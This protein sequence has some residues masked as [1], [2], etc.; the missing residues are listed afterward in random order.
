M[1]F[2]FTGLGGFTTCQGHR[3]IAAGFD[4]PWQGG[5]KG[6]GLNKTCLGVDQR[7]RGYIFFSWL[8]S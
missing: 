1:F 2:L 6:S 4:L 5:K 7:V 3:E 8:T